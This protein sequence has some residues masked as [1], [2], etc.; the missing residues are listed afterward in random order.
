MKFFKRIDLPQLQAQ[1]AWAPALESNAVMSFRLQGD[2]DLVCQRP[3]VV[4]AVLNMAADADE[5]RAHVPG[6]R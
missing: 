4:N 2:I 5:P 1:P 3:A 6:D